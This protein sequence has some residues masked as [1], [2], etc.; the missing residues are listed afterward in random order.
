MCGICGF[1]VD[2]KALAP[3]DWDGVLQAMTA[4][5]SHRGPD[6]D[7]RFLSIHQGYTIGLGHRRLSII[8]LSELGRQ[9][10][11]NE[12]GNVRIVFNG[13][14]YNYRD[15]QHCLREKN[16][17]FRSQSDTETI[18]HH[19][20]ER[21]FACVDDFNGMFG[22][23]VWDKAAATL[24]MARDR[25]GIK[26][27]FYTRIDKGIAF[28]SEIKSLLLVPGVRPELAPEAVD[29]YLALGYV[30]GP[31]TIFKG[32]HSLLP[33]HWLAWR[34]G[35]V[36]IERYW[37]PDT[38][39]EYHT[40]SDAD[41]VDEYDCLLNAA[42]DRHLVADVPIGAFLS[43]GLDSSLICAIAAKRI[44]GKLKTFFIGFGGGGDE[45]EFA[46]AAARHIGADHHERM[47][48]PL[49]AAMLPKLL[50]HLEQP[51]FDNSI[52]P[53]FLV[54]QFACEEGKVVLSGDGGDEPFV[55]YGWTRA[56][57]GIPGIGIAGPAPDWRWN[58]QAGRMGLFKR[59]IYDLTHG[60]TERYL[61]RIGTLK[62]LRDWLYRPEF[63]AGLS[64]DGIGTMQQVIDS[65]TV[66]EN[67][68]RY[69]L[70]DLQRYLPE[71]VLFKVDRMSMANS[72]EVR[73]PL[74]DHQL[75]E[76]TL[77]LPWRLR[78]NGGKGKIL[79]RQVAARYLPPIILQPRKQGFT[80]PVG[81]WLKGPTGDLAARAF[82][83]P[84]FAE[85]G[86]VRP[87]AAQELLALHRSGR[88][89]LG[90]RI[91]SL[92]V[93]EVWSRI[94]LDGQSWQQSL[95]EIFTETGDTRK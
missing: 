52:L 54:S 35:E 56:A 4:A 11:E 26:P 22:F 38:A 46:A 17:R 75:V 19:Y 44:T 91:W 74:L 48:E 1:V 66:R 79:L 88:C 2:E 9:P 73:P 10:M 83:S 92:L 31:C 30:P 21:K 43:G 86:I 37:R 76:W 57:I 51:L 85:R 14:I 25:L 61:R 72:L 95:A 28:A 3:A 24:F 94:W 77:R 47:A 16:H 67:R 58:Y 42:V 15:L 89:E 80:V 23:A 53:T 20:E 84:R 49:L 82:A 90:H 70:T 29:Q 6:Q 18:I 34:A 63:A 69:P 81:R 27:L 45:R 71:D 78:C 68:E 93:L 64:V 41:L 12:D 50:W 40:G 32:I 13:E 39:G 5:Q 65:L 60:P 33:G 55:G 36:S 8:D 7:G 62:P 87:E 59:G